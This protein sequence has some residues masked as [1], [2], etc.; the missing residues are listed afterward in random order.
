[1]YWNIVR[2]GGSS[3]DRNKQKEPCVLH[4]ANV[5][6]VA[7]SM[8]YG[9]LFSSLDAA[10]QMNT[11]SKAGQCLYQRSSC[12]VL[13]CFIWQE[14]IEVSGVKLAL[15]GL[16]RRQ[17][18]IKTG[19]WVESVKGSGGFEDEV[20]TQFKSTHDADTKSVCMQ[21]RGKWNYD[22]YLLLERNPIKPLLL[23][24]TILIVT[25]MNV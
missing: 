18:L 1:M 13:L 20:Q 22:A 6:L 9:T 2:A 8:L 16:F 14:Y 3:S 17:T 10:Q 4:F 25:Q 21:I 11:L 7:E 24:Q 23:L 5:R 19:V 15:S 12:V